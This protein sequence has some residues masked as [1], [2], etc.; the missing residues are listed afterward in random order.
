MSTHPNVIL[1]LTIKTEGTTRKLLRE[2]LSQNR[3]EIT[4][5][6]LPL[7]LDRSGKPIAHA[8]TKENLH[9]SRGDD[10]ICIGNF[11]YDTLVMEEEYDESWQIGGKE[12]DLIIFDLVTYGYGE[13]ISW[14]DLQKRV[15]DLE[16]WAVQPCR[17]LTYYISVSANYW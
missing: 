13:E 5:N 6:N 11:S 4:D 10:Q 9:I 15:D 8:K 12:G 16:L 14:K 7:M 2:L 17:N 3:E 1:K